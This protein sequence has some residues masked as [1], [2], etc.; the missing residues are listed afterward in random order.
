MNDGAQFGG[1]IDEKLDLVRIEESHVC[2]I[3]MFC[4]SN[5]KSVVKIIK[6]RRLKSIFN[7]KEKMFESEVR[8]WIFVE[9][10]ESRSNWS[11]R[12]IENAPEKVRLHNDVKIWLKMRKEN[13]VFFFKH[14]D[15]FLFWFSREKHQNEIKSEKRIIDFVFGIRPKEASTSSSKFRSNS[16]QNLQRTTTKRKAKKVF[17][18]KSFQPVFRCVFLWYR[19]RLTD[20][21]SEETRFESDRREKRKFR[22]ELVL[23][24]VER[25]RVE[26]VLVL[27]ELEPGEELLRMAEFVVLWGVRRVERRLRNQ[28]EL[29]RTEHVFSREKSLCLFEFFVRQTL[30]PNGWKTKRTSSYRVLLPFDLSLFFT[31]R[32]IVFRRFGEVSRKNR[33]LLNRIFLSFDVLFVGVTNEVVAH[34]RTKINGFGSM[35]N[36][37]F[38]FLFTRSV[39]RRNRVSLFFFDLRSTCEC[40]TKT[41]D[42]RRCSSECRW[43]SSTCNVPPKLN[44]TKSFLSPTSKKLD[45]KTNSS[46]ASIVRSFRRI[47]PAEFDKS[48][49][50]SV[51]SL[52]IREEI[53]CWKKNRTFSLSVKSF[54]REVKS[55]NFSVDSTSVWTKFR[56]PL[57]IERSCRSTSS[58]RTNSSKSS[59]EKMFAWIS[60]DFSA[61]IDSVK[62]KTN[63]WE[64]SAIF[65]CS[66]RTNRS[67][68]V[69]VEP[70]PLLGMFGVLER[71]CSH[72]ATNKASLFCS[73]GK[74]K[75]CPVKSI[76]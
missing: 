11:L 19:T 7:L 31:V 32:E 15:R 40:C 4:W 26:Q 27:V 36:F 13:E 18:E 12:K 42:G 68:V 16:R 17:E 63:F 20:F 8:R 6:T 45:E 72:R 25:H 24:F 2:E 69:F 22:T 70:T 21:S 35:W 52:W 55:H 60:K 65:N 61:Q 48:T 14:N 33:F 10:R 76:D 41:S 73:V 51:G 28:L 44:E 9:R 66:V 54:S 75:K 74:K 37:S 47:Q 67:V 49:G 1:W 38:S 71:I 57:R 53:R 30:V 23:L 43:R 34:R 39:E 62:V 50:R 5:D 56:N 29:F 58:G 46:F 64:I 3:K 59:R